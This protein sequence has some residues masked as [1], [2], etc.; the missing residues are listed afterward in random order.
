MMGGSAQTFSTTSWKKS[1]INRFTWAFRSVTER[2]TDGTTSTM[3][4]QTDTTVDRQV[5]REERWMDRR[6]LPVDKQ[7]LR[8]NKRV[9]QVEKWVLR[10]GEEYYEQPEK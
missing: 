5:L 6:V 4:W 2:P 1:E 3:G 10:L 9:L 8:V 7:V